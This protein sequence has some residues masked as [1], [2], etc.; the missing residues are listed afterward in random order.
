MIPNRYK[1]LIFK[2][3]RWYASQYR[4]VAMI[5]FIKTNWFVIGLVLLALL[6]WYRK[7][8]RFNLGGSSADQPEKYTDAS[9]TKSTGGSWLGL[10]GDRSS[11]HKMPQIDTATAKA[12]LRRFGKVTKPEQE[13]FGLPASVMLACAYVNSHAGQRATVG[14]AN[15]YF[16]LRCG[17]GWTSGNVDIEGQ[18]FRRY[19]TPWESFRDASNTFVAQDWCKQAIADRLSREAWVA[20]LVK[21]GCSDVADAEQ[22]MLRI[23]KAYRLHELDGK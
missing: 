4:L 20:L 8:F 16:A 1:S 7:S 17:G 6:G 11:A 5:R 15:N 10:L 12:F 22:E 18:C 2:I 9:G 19:A 3:K 13:K 14:G 23:I 21:Q